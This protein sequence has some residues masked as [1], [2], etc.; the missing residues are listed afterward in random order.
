MTELHC[1]I[2]GRV[3]G[4]AY[5]EFARSI[6]SELGLKG[7]V[8]NLP[9]GSVEIVAQGDTGLLRVYEI[10]LKQGPSGARVNEIYDEWKEAE[11]PF[12]DFRIV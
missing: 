1:I 7:F 11:T 3:Q 4:V 8:A 6:A 10:H 9:D 12:E 5:R 2:T